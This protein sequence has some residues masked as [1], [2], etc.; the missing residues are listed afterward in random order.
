[1]KKKKKEVEL[2]GKLM[3][4]ITIGKSALFA[5]GGQ[6]YHTSRV[7]ALHEH[8]DEHVHFETINTHYHLSM[9][10]FPLAAVCPLPVSLAAC[11]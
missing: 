8:N 2:C 9:R 7:V 11:A 6:I 5:A 1:M 3:C 4:P 10:P